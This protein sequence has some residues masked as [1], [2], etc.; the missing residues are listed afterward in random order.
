MWSGCPEK[1]CKNVGGVDCGQAVL[2]NGVRMLVVL[3]VVRLSCKKRCKNVAGVDCG[4]AVLRNGVVVLIV[5]RLSCQE[6]V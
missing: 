1:R 6:T 4:Q 3:I 5:V 2:R